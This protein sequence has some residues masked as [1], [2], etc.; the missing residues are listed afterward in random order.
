MFPISLSIVSKIGSLFSLDNKFDIIFV[1]E[2]FQ[3]PSYFSLPILYRAKK[4]QLTGD[5]KQ[6][7]GYNKTI[8]EKVNSFELFQNIF[9]DYKIEDLNKIYNDFSFFKKDSNFLNLFLGN[10]TNYT[11]L[12]NN[13]W[14]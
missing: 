12:I 7:S 11:L 4:I 3:M 2:S 9:K 1:D 14:Y 8:A 10:F 6:I 5:K 13:F